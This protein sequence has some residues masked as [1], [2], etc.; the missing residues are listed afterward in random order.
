ME[1]FD[2]KTMYFCMCVRCCGV[3]GVWSITGQMLGCG[4][5]GVGGWLWKCGVRIVCGGVGW[6]CQAEW[7]WSSNEIIYLWK[8]TPRARPWAHISSP[9]ASGGSAPV[10]LTFHLFPPCTPYLANLAVL[11]F[12]LLCCP[13]P[14]LLS[15]SPIPLVAT[16][17]YP[18]FNLIFTLSI[19]LY[20]SFSSL[21]VPV[22]F[23]LVLLLIANFIYA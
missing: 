20:L 6:G 8:P 17:P 1:R 18:S 16:I 19:L 13:S 15:S 3:V 5:V 11:F 14:C 2:E 21:V 22:F 9:G 10:P 12:T 7:C 23:L 4:G